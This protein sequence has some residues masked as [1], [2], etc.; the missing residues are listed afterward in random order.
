M[1]ERNRGKGRDNEKRSRREKGKIDCSSQYKQAAS[2]ET[3]MGGKDEMR[4]VKKQRARHTC[5]AIVAIRLESANT[6]THM[7]RH[8]TQTQP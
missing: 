7:H 8:Q 6:Q 5:C 3:S 4:L 1:E 2:E